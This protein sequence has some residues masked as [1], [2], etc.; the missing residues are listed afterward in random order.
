MGGVWWGDAGGGLN[1]G[2]SS[3]P[4]GKAVR[5]KAV[6]SGRALQAIYT[7]EEECCRQHQALGPLV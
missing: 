3:P 6:G 7:E 5:R 1:G 2:S 4:K